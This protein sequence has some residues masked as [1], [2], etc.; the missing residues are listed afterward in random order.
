MMTGNRRKL[1]NRRS[2]YDDVR[3]SNE[4]LVEICGNSP[5]GL[6]YAIPNNRYSWKRILFGWALHHNR[7]SGLGRLQRELDGRSL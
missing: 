5:T 1:R 4:Y 6:I 2:E 3:S 7:R